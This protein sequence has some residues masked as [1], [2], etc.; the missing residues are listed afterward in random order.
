MSD[1]S[2]VESTLA[3]L[4]QHTADLSLGRGAV[5]TCPARRSRLWPAVVRELRAMW[6]KLDAAMTLIE[7]E[8]EGGQP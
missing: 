5:A 1:R 4:A 7:Q 8:V 3:D 6:P 2:D